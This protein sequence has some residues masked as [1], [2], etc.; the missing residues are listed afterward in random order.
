MK[1]H[2][3]NFPICF[4][5]ILRGAIF[6]VLLPIAV[7]FCNSS[8]AW[9]VDLGTAIDY[10]VLGASTVTNTGPTTLNGD[11]GLSPGPSITGLG[12][13]T[14]SGAVHQ[15]D[16]AAAQAQSD[17]VAA[18]LVLAG[19]PFDSDLSGQNL[20]TVGTLFP[21]VYRFSSDAFL[22]GTLTLDSQGVDTAQYVFQIG[23][24]LTTASGSTVQ[25]LN[26]GDGDDVFWQVGSSATLGTTT[27]FQ[28]S[29]LALT[30]I[31]LQTGA[32]IG[33]G[34]AL[35]QNGAVTLDTNTITSTCSDQEGSGTGGTGGG[36]G[37]TGNGGGTGA[38]PEPDS[39]FLVGAGIGLAIFMAFK[40]SRQC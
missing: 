4:S 20:G 32:Q 3:N 30:S 26:G 21:G 19:L 36:T 28:G 38:V 25:I 29:I 34:R 10:A 5:A 16:A 8:S 11:L 35:A 22:T 15:T 39:L 13:I 12:S 7:L 14:L 17:N 6:L 31:A 37:G 1:N 33:C 9:A 18:Y 23:S 24:A 2:Q 40:K 27:S